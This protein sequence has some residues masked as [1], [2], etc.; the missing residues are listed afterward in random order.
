MLRNFQPFI[1]YKKLIELQA[2]SVGYSISKKTKTNNNL[3]SQNS[4]QKSKKL[5]KHQ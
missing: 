4:I 3:N 1:D 2:N 5:K